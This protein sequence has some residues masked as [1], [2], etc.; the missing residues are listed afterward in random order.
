MSSSPSSSS[1]SSSSPASPSPAWIHSRTPSI[2]KLTPEARKQLATFSIHSTIF[3]SLISLRILNA[4]TNRTFFQ[5]DEYFQSLEPAW[6]VAFAGSGAWVTWEWQQQLRSFLHPAIFTVLFKSVNFLCNL[7]HLSPQRTA[8]FLAISPRILQAIF[9]ALGDWSTARLAGRLWGS[10]VGWI[11]LCLSL[12]SA[13]QWF[14]GVRTFANSLETVITG[15]GLGLWP[16]ELVASMGAKRRV[17]WAETRWA[18]AAAAAACVLRPTNVL[19]W[20]CLGAFAV[21]NAG[22]RRVR[23]VME[24]VWI[25]LT[26]LSLN[27]LIDR[28]YYGVW[29]F[30]PLTFLKFNVLHSLSVFYGSNVNHYYL[31]QGLPLLLTSFLPL[32]LFALYRSLS[33]SATS[34]SFQLAS[35][36]LVVTAVYSCISHKEVR[37]LYPLLPI[38]HVLTA[39][40]LHNLRISDSA[41]S[42]ILMVMIALNIPVAYYGSMVHQRGVVDVMA[43]LSSTSDNWNSTGFLMPCHSTPWRASMALPM[44]S[45]KKMWALTCEPPVSLSVEERRTYVD[46]ADQFYN[47]PKGFIRWYVGD[48]KKYEWPDRI[49]TFE[50]LGDLNNLIPTVT[51]TSALGGT[52]VPAV[53]NYEICWRAFNSHLHDD[54]RRRGDV[55]VWCRKSEK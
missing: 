53:S 19:V 33:S 50:D 4:V 9:C 39:N 11:A 6:D 54:W 44:S 51:G 23:L 52:G 20:A 24:A 8:E 29:T 32:A 46:E 49:V 25:G 38:L 30:P 47:N 43:H 55:L 41:R 14:C 45:D 7:L 21:V 35:T 26:V 22:R 31:S 3:L 18:L 40:T 5:P 10:D 17:D 15:V 1:P 34:P 28:A 12:G 13:W 27:A 2:T 36:V 16:W 37:F 48:G 42:R